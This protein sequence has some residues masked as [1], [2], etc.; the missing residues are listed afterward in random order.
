V[1]SEG[2]V[3]LGLVLMCAGLKLGCEGAYL[4]WFDGGSDKEDRG[5]YKPQSVLPS[6]HR[7]CHLLS[8]RGK[9]FL[10]L[11]KSPKIHRSHSHQSLSHKHKYKHKLEHKQNNHFS[12][13]VMGL[14]VVHC[15]A[16]LT[17]GQKCKSID[18]NAREEEFES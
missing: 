5:I 6:I 16:P 1:R 10:I 11:G 7:G 2:L 18:T 9:A 17:L 13:A 15:C 4:R 3:W 14:F 8:N 12:K